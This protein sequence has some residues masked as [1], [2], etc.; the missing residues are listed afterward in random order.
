M[1]HDRMLAVLANLADGIDPASGTAFPAES[2]YQHP[3]TVRALFLALRR[4]YAAGSA[5]TSPA[6]GSAST[7]PAAGS[8]STSPTAR[9]AQISHAA[10][11]SMA[12]EATPIGRKSSGNS[13]TTGKGSNAGKTW[14]PEEDQRLATA[15]D[16]GEDIGALTKTHGRSRLA[17]EIRLAKLG[18]VPMPE[19]TLY[20][21]KPQPNELPQTIPPADVRPAKARSASAPRRASESGGLRYHVATSI[22]AAGLRI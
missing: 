14:T 4:L 18:R 6:A 11:P 15:F 10:A 3:E 13:R 9:S 8:A 1:D 17:L 2:P 7:S 22:A 16:A 21:N 12:T 5:S 20:G 19:K